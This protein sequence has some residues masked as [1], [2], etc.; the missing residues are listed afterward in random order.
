V[1]RDPLVGQAIAALAGVDVGGVARSLSVQAEDAIWGEVARE[2]S[3][4]RANPGQTNDP[5]LIGV[6]KVL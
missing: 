4:I 2:E 6:L 5:L 1:A 3:A